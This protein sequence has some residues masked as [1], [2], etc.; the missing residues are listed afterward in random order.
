MSSAVTP[1]HPL[2]LD[3]EVEVEE[4]LVGSTMSSAVTPDHPLEL[5]VDV[6]EEVDD[7]LVLV[8]DPPLVDELDV[9]LEEVLVLPPVDELEVEV[10]VELE[11]LLVLLVEELEVDVEPDV[12]L[13]LLVEE[14]DELE[15]V[16]VRLPFPQVGKKCPIAC[17][18]SAC[19][20]MHSNIPEGNST[21]SP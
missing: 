4:L 13:V 8:L 12:L 19:K 18:G 21:P 16:S 10:D 14:L 6:D 9:E 5:D 11:V 2:E 7:V 17:S 1:D 15:V 20:S 3:V